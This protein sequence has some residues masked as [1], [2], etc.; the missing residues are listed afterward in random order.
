MYTVKQLSD[1]AGITLTTK[2]VERAAEAAGTTAAA[3][4]TEKTRAILTR[5]VIPLP[6]PAPVAD[7]LYIAV[8]GTG[9]PMT[10]AETTGRAGKYPDGRART[11]EAKLAALF[12]Q[13]GPGPD[14]RPVR[15]P[16]STSY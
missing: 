9:V 12:T 14:G 10:P 4:I 8:D 3:A 6:P 13:T 15:D 5:R 16:D 7:M 2:R 11:R 1:L